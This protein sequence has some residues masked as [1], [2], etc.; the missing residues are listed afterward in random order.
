MDTELKETIRDLRDQIL[1]MREDKQPKSKEWEEARMGR[2][3]TTPG[4]LGRKRIITEKDTGLIADLDF[5]SDNLLMTLSGGAKAI[6]AVQLWDTTTAACET[7][8]YLPNCWQQTCSIEKEA[9]EIFAVGGLNN[10]PFIFKTKE[11]ITEFNP[12]GEE[13]AKP[14]VV[15]TGH[16]S[17]IAEVL[18]TKTN[19]LA[20]CADESIRLWDIEKGVCSSKFVGHT[21]D[22]FCI[23]NNPVEQQT[24]IV[25]GA[26]DFTARLW[27][28]RTLTGDVMR[29]QSQLTFDTKS[30]DVNG[31]A[32]FPDGGAFAAALNN[33][34]VYLYDTKA[35]TKLLTFRHESTFNNT[36]VEQVKFSAS[37]R[38]LFVRYS[39]MLVHVF[40]VAGATHDSE[41]G[42]AINE[43]LI[44]GAI[45]NNDNAKAIE[46]APSG[47]VL[48]IGK[49]N[50]KDTTA[51]LYWP[52]GK[53]R[54]R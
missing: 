35:S 49:Q 27:D 46:V 6:G 3:F 21:G 52:T 50:K 11:L 20:S 47:A 14:N 42:E 15:L 28:C 22:V 37:G 2:E 1:K 48:G 26:G 51:H 23:D 10:T 9:S 18:F 25:S 13:T 16:Q 29:T 45:P 7:L 40:D 24:M 38:L 43:C 32:Y 30:R 36:G 33:S 17:G 31:V 39:N 5:G 41:E 54:K 4:I 19:E 34:C 44:Q 12:M 53:L 8:V